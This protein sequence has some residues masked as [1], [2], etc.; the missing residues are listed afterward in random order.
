MPDEYESP[1][2]DIKSAVEVTKTATGEVPRLVRYTGTTVEYTGKAIQ[3]AGTAVQAAGRGIS[4]L[5]AIPYVGVVFAGI[6]GGLQATG[7]GINA[8]GKGVSAAGKGM[9]A[10][11]RGLGK[12]KS[13]S[14]TAGSLLKGGQIAK[15][16]GGPLGWASLASRLIPYFDKLKDWS[17]KIMMGAGALGAYLLYLLGLKILGFVT[18]LTFG[19]ITGLPLLAIPGVGPFAYAGWTGY[20]ASRGWMDPL[21]TIHLA[22]HPWELV[23]NPL[24]KAWGFTKGAFNTVT[25]GP[26]QFT[27]GIPGYV[28]GA[29]STAGTWVTGAASTLWGGITGIGGGLVSGAASLSGALFSGLTGAA[30]GGAGLLAAAVGGAFGT[31]GIASTILGVTTG[32]AFFTSQQDAIIGGTGDNEFFTIKKTVNPPRI[33]NSEL[34][35]DITYSITLT[36]KGNLTGIV[37][38]DKLVVQGKNGNFEVTQDKNGATIPPCA[39]PTT[40]AAGATWDCRFSI[41]ATNTSDRNFTDGVANN[42]VTVTAGQEGQ[43]AIT[44]SSQPAIT[45]IGAPPVDCPSGWPT[46][47]GTITQ[48]PTGPTSHARLAQLFGEAA[49]DIGNNPRGTPTH[50][51]FSGKVIKVVEDAGIGYGGDGY[52]NHVDVEGRCGDTYFKARWAHLQFIDG[53]ITVGSTVTSG[54]VIGGIDNTGHSGGDHL[55]YSFF[56]LQIFSYIP[57][58]Q[59]LPSSCEEGT[60]TPCNISW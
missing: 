24:S 8:L 4:A 32:A 34:P 53:A 17:K 5:G 16:A 31:I 42:V 43:A 44:D 49:I 55:H 25:Y 46:D 59:R 58:G 57:D 15:V 28:S 1:K 18:G 50:A 29:V 39:T 9:K 22:T 3:F 10:A 21:G 7:T 37:I 6:G 13:I 26:I 40:L 56:G 19:A 33:A 51:T 54:Q 52:G 47:H 38:T 20:W 14:G 12:L 30:S 41:S 2:E 36:A 45:T 48:G 23:T 60:S 35:R 11:G 27:G